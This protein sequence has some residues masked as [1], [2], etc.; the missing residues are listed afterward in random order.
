MAKVPEG[1][2]TVMP[3][4]II[5]DALKFMAFMQDVFGATEKMKMLTHDGQIMHGEVFIGESCIMFA[6]SGGEWGVNNAGLYVYVDDADAT[7]QKA[8]DAGSEVVTELADQSY[9]RSGGIK[10]PFGNT[11]WIVTGKS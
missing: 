6:N 8:L 7:Y 4:I 10:D 11:W 2:Q 1:Y 3:Y 9:G 5:K